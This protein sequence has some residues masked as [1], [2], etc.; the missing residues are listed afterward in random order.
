M[1]RTEKIR[2]RLTPDELE[3]LKQCSAASQTAKFENGKENF[4]YYIR[5]K[6]LESSRY[7]NSCL[8]QQLRD[9][10]YELRKIGTNI[11]QVTKKINAGYGTLED[12]QEIQFCQRQI[13]ELFEKCQEEAEEKWQ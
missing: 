8:E 12:L 5:E 13:V 6:L 10:R 9:I 11:N 3:H 1:K 4:S 2:I 7:K